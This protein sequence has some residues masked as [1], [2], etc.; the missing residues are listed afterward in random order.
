MLKGSLDY[1]LRAAEAFMAA[2]R[3]EDAAEAARLR[4]EAYRFVEL[5][6]EL[7]GTIAL[8]GADAV[9]ATEISMQPQRGQ[10]LQ[11][12]GLGAPST[13]ASPPRK[14]PSPVSAIG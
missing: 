13:E 7:E 10:P 3:S 9:A 6:Q 1:A 4:R 5:I 8:D 2:N 14:S 12:E 11:G